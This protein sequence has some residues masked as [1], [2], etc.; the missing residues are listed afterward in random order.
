MTSNTT[1]FWQENAAI[2]NCRILGT[3]LETWQKWLSVW[4]KINDRFLVDG[5][6]LI[7]SEDLREE[8][9]R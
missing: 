1:H 6:I 7:G 3:C 2:I 5:R 8:F 9:K 4:I